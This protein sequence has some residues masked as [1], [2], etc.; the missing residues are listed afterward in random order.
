MKLNER[1]GNDMEKASKK[2]LLM[3][4]SELVESFT[5]MKIYDGVPVTRKS[6]Q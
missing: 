1:H 4:I 6:R 2:K 5:G 3:Y